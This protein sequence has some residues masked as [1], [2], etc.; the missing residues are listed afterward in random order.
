MPGSLAPAARIVEQRFAQRSVTMVSERAATVSLPARAALAQEITQPIVADRVRVVVDLESPIKALWI[1][2]GKTRM[3]TPIE[4]VGEPS[5][6]TN[7]F[8]ASASYADFAR[9]DAT[10]L[11]D[12]IIV[13][14]ASGSVG[15]KRGNE[16][17][18]TTP[19]TFPAFVPPVTLVLPER[20]D[21]G[22]AHR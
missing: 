21:N 11:A 5:R 19:A 10:D 1:V 22:V 17:V 7:E 15:I 9:H 12:S 18:Y 3:V 16:V 6:L 13:D 20:V 4:M 14:S 8:I 2:R